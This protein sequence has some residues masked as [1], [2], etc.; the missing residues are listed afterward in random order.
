[1]FGAVGVDGCNCPPKARGWDWD[2]HHDSNSVR[3]WYEGAG[4]S[5]LWTGAGNW[6]V[7]LDMDLNLDKP[8]RYTYADAKAKCS[9]WGATLVREQDALDAVRFW[10]QY[11]V[12]LFPT[13]YMEFADNDLD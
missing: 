9:A 2:Y 8:T 12:T 6:K 1:M 4:I 11:L 3:C 10:Y 7:F 5:S 13:T